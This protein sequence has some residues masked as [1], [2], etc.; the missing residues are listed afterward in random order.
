M[1]N[2]NTVRSAVAVIALFG[3]AACSPGK[4]G[5]APAPQVSQSVDGVQVL[6]ETVQSASVKTAFKDSAVATSSDLYSRLS[7]ITSAEVRRETGS[8][9][10]M[11][12][13][14]RDAGGVSVLVLSGGADFSNMASSAEGI[15]VTAVVDHDEAMH[16][17]NISARIG[18]NLDAIF[19]FEDMSNGAAAGDAGSQTGKQGQNQGQNQKQEQPKQ[20]VP[21]QDQPKQDL[22]K[23]DQPKQDAPKQEQPKQ[24]APKQEQPKQEAP[25]QEQPKQEAPKQEQPKQDAPKQEQPKQDAPKQDMPK[26]DMPKQELPK[27]DAPKQDMPKQEMPKQDAPKQ[28]IPKQEQ[29]KQSAAAGQVSGSNGA[30]SSHR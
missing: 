10:H 27:Q 4:S 7:S 28:D 18:D 29:P 15:K 19:S 6:K 8:E 25:K 3:V 16:V 14:M 24:E 5:N 2:K 9:T 30:V 23:Q 12:I 13:D 26:Q 22:P 11:V 17:R 21:K 20:D 1:I